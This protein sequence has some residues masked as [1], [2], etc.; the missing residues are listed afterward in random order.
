MSNRPWLFPVCVICAGADQILKVGT[1][2]EAWKILLDK[3]PIADGHKFLSA[4]KI[5]MDVEHGI[6]EPADARDAFIAAAEEAGVTIVSVKSSA[7]CNERTTKV[8][9]ER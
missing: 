2:R 3:W 6:R 9:A 4:L 1:T 7:V 5:C 8:M